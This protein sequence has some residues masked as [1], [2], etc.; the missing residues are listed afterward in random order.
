M[1]GELPVT[2]AFPQGP[3]FGL[4]DPLDLNIYN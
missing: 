3:E 2:L 4:L 1:T